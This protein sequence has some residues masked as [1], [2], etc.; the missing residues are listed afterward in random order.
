MN[1]YHQGQLLRSFHECI[2]ALKLLW[3]MRSV[4]QIPSA[5]SE[6]GFNREAASIAMGSVKS[7]IISEVHE[8]KKEDVKKEDP[9]KK[10]EGPKVM[11][12]PPP[13]RR[14]G[15]GR[16]RT[17]HPLQSPMFPP[18]PPPPPTAPETPTAPTVPVEA[19]A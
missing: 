15:P 10:K 9:E 13:V 7:E 11:G 17:M 2:R 18:P 4:L 19:A 3:T 8:K 14:A 6:K 16:D 5:R 12:P 1:L